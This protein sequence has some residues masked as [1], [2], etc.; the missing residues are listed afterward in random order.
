MVDRVVAGFV[1]RKDQRGGIDDN[2]LC[3][4]SGNEGSSSTRGY[5]SQIR[6]Q[7]AFESAGC[8]GGSISIINL[9]A[10]GNGPGEGFG[11]DSEVVRGIIDAVV[12]VIEVAL[13]DDIAGYIL[14]I[15]AGKGTSQFIVSHQSINHIS[16]SGVRVTIDL[17]LGIRLD[18]EGSLRDYTVGI[19]DGNNRVV[20]AAI[21][22]G[23]GVGGNRKGFVGA[24]IGVVV[25]F[26]QIGDRVTCHIAGV[27]W[28]GGGAGGGIVGFGVGLCSDSEGFR[29]DFVGGIGCCC[30]IVGR[31]GS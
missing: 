10:G 17:G 27:G 6:I 5:I 16:Q 23:Y 2:G 25:G 19:L 8:G 12:R 15:I 30:V 4:I 9:A 26:G 22:I 31:T 20:F 3:D 28:N 11:G 14:T 29:G 1:A 24:R 21:A 13:V 7:D 18:G